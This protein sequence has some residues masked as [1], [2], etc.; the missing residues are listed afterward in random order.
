MLLLTGSVDELV[1]TGAVRTDQPQC[2]VSSPCWFRGEDDPPSIRRPRRIERV[3]VCQRRRQIRDSAAVR[4]HPENVLAVVKGNP[5]P[6]W[7]QR[8]SVTDAERPQSAS[9]RIHHVNHGRAVAL[10]HKDDPT[11]AAISSAR[12]GRGRAGGCRRE[13]AQHSR[14]GHPRY[15]CC[16]SW[17]HSLFSKPASCRYVFV[18]GCAVS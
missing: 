14:R 5:P 16:S 7:R 10:P 17:L 8:W 1:Q 12:R 4:M 6:V 18:H 2:R 11:A 15:Q 9:L 3:D 13:R